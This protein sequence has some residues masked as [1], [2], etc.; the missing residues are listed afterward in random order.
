MVSATSVINCVGSIVCQA[1][2]VLEA[3]DTALADHGLMMP[4]DLG[5]KGSCHIGGNVATNAGGLRLIRYGSL[6]ANTLGLVAV[7]SLLTLY[8]R[9]INKTS[10]CYLSLITQVYFV[11]NIFFYK[12]AK[13]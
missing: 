5:A 9:K 12:K 6:Q 13:K 10:P 1:G 11:L 4:L 2:C 8:T 7:S 3:L